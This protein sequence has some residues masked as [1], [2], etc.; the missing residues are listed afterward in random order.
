[1]SF[2][3]S[4]GL[5]TSCLITVSTG[6]LFA[7]YVQ[8]SN[9]AVP[10]NQ[11]AAATPLHAHSLDGQMGLHANYTKLTFTSNPKH[12]QAGQKAQWTLRISDLKTGLPVQKFL[13]MHDQL[14]H[15]V[16]VSRNMSFYDHIH[17]I[18]RGN[19]TFTISY[20]LPR[21][22]QY[23]LYADYVT[24]AMQHEVAR[25]DLTV[26]GNNPLPSQLKYIPDT[27][28]GM[29]IIKHFRSHEEGKEPVPNATQY[30]VALMPMPFPVRAGAETMLHF[31]IRD[32]KGKPL[33]DLQPYMG[34]MGHAVILSGDGEVYLHTHP[35]DKEMPE[36]ATA[37]TG[38]SSKIKGTSVRRNQTAPTNEM[39]SM[40]KILP[41]D[42]RGGPDIIFHAMFPK[43]G[44]YRVWG[45]FM[46]KNRVITADYTLFVLPSKNK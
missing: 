24:A 33:T 27:P 8:R 42:T 3:K 20:T 30:E 2:P 35:D 26:A 29:W 11:R 14:M 32:A 45:Q 12:L 19:G 7:G 10:P 28:Q 31:Q 5:R 15:L 34:A 25:H 38:N 36:M 21:A 9:A 18:Y 6:L 46:R 43:P 4:L 37:N 1:M 39:A 13:K 40:M 16:V 41:P 17:P 22:G 23:R 44:F